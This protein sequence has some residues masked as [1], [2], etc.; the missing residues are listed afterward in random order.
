MEYPAFDDLPSVARLLVGATQGGEVFLRPDLAPAALEALLATLDGWRC[1]ILGDRLIWMPPANPWSSS[2]AAEL[3]YRLARAIDDAGLPI[4]RF[5]ADAGFILDPEPPPYGRLV[6]PDFALVRA[7][8]I[9]PQTAPQRGFWPLVPDLAIEVR[10][11]SDRPS[12][13][14]A[15]LE[16][17]APIESVRLWAIDSGERTVELW[18]HARQVALLV[19]PDDELELE[20]LVPGWRLSL[21]ELWNLLSRA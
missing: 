7:E 14:R 11:P 2:L 18:R 8:R 20:D 10:S 3:G 17:Y 15:K 12:V 19:Q 1:D 21:Q 16:V 6:S 9:T 5:G 4:R 13:W